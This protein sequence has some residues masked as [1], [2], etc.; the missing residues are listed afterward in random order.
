VKKVVIRPV[1]DPSSEE[2]V[3]RLR[4]DSFPYFPEVHDFGFYTYVYHRWWGSSRLANELHRWAAVTAEGEVVGHLSALPQYYRID[5]RRVVAHTPADYMIHPRYGFYALSL[6]RTF[7]RTCENGVA[8]DM[9]PATIDIQT[10]LGFEAAGQLNYALKLLN[11]SRLPVPPVPARARRLLRLPERYGAPA[12]EHSGQETSGEGTPQEFLD[13]APA[14]R[15]RLPLPAPVKRLMNG[16]LRLVDEALSSGFGGG[17]KVEVLEGF[18]ASFDELFERVAA[19]VPCVA[20]KDA[21]FLRWR[22]GPGSPQDPVTVLGV[23]GEDGLRGYAVLKVTDGMDGYILDLTALPGHRD[24][25]RVLTLESVRFLGQAEAQ[26]IRYRFQDSPVSA[27]PEDLW[28]LGFFFRK[29]RR[30]TLLTKFS[31]PALHETARR[32]ANWSYTLGDGEASF[33]MR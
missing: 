18:D 27:R 20:E 17:L 2:K 21:A 28:R 22:Y 10:R 16:G 8:C 33:W 9:V 14:V 7:F 15:P 1:E 32:I 11:V 6:M 30:N 24:V 3:S 13:R 23:K 25:T 5:G 4:V 12:A 26:V 19:A 31:D 29:G